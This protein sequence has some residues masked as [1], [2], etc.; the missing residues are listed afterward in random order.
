MELYPAI[1]L[2]AGRCVRL[3][4]GRFDAETVYSDDPVQTAL[5]WQS[6]GARWLHIV[7]LDGAREGAPQQLHVV[8][9]ICHAVSIPVQ[10]GGGLRDEQAVSQAFEAGATRVVLGSAAILC[11][12]FAERM[13]HEWGERVALGVDVREGKAAIRGWQEQTEVDVLELI[14]RMVDLGARRVIVTDISRDGTLQGPN[15]QLLKRLVQEAGIPII[16]S[17]GVSSLYDLLSLK[18]AGV[19]GA[20][21]GKAL[22]TGNINLKEAVEQVKTKC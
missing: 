16:A 12:E 2:R 9:S 7:D 20:I 21:I 3:L 11:P 22:Y 13:F 8:Q 19:E 15:L 10:F 1:D 18:E 5:R 4:Q 17:G 14:Q 6:E